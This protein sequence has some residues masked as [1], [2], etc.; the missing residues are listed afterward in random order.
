MANFK[1]FVKNGWHPE[2]EGTTLRGQVVRFPRARR[3]LPPLTRHCHALP[4][5]EPDGPQ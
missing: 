1:D 5:V 4:A 3:G 2:K